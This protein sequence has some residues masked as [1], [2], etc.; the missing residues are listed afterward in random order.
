[1]RV[2]HFVWAS[3]IIA[4]ALFSAG[5]VRAK[6][7]SAS[8]TGVSTDQTVS[9]GSVSALSA[10]AEPTLWGIYGAHSVRD[11]PINNRETAD[12]VIAMSEA[13]LRP[14]MKKYGVTA[15]VDR[16][17]SGLEHTFLWVVETTEP[18]ELEGF[19]VELGVARFNTLKIVPL[20]TFEDGVVPFVRRVH[21]MDD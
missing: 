9:A 19:C 7:A 11:C 12:A 6:T 13:D 21:G 4:T 17:H 2:K 14:L 5:C 1:M 16:Y 10:S 20:V 8:V 15:F 3:T 18:H